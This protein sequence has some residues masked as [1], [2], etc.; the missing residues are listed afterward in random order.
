MEPAFVWSMLVLVVVLIG[1]IVSVRPLVLQGRFFPSM[2]RLYLSFLPPTNLYKPILNIQL[3]AELEACA[4]QFRFVHPYVGDYEAGLVRA[5][6][7]PVLVGPTPVDLRIFI[8]F[9]TEG[10]LYEA[11]IGADQSPWWGRTES[12]V[13][14]L[15]YSV[16]N[17]LPVLKVVEC[18][19]QVK[20]ADKAVKAQYQNT[21]FYV[22]K[23]S[24]K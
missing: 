21:R 13:T 15:R 24:E 1:A 8:A 5:G 7:V 4:R 12:G 14:L 10:Q 2:R 3:D 18:T 16:P 17:D 20:H 6:P 11:V 23:A 9:N 19:M 22:R